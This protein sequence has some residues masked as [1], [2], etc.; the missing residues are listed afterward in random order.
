VVI[1]SHLV[2]WCGFKRTHDWLC[3]I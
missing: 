1:V 2:V 3:N